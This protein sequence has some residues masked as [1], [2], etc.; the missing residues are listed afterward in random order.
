MR[1]HESSTGSSARTLK[2]LATALLSAVMLVSAVSPVGARPHQPA[3]DRQDSWVGTWA[4]ASSHGDTEHDFSGRTLRMVLHTSVGGRA[5]RVRLSNAFNERAQVVDHVTVALAANP[6]ADRRKQRRGHPAA[7]VPG[8][9]REVTFNSSGRTVVPAHARVVSDPVAMAVP[10]DSDLLVSIHLAEQRGPATAHA[11]ARQ[12]SYVSGPGDHTAAESAESYTATVNSWFYVDGLDVLGRGARGAVVA[13]GD[14]ITDGYG[15]TEGAN[16][17]WPD[18]LADRLRHQPPWRRLGVLNAG[19]SG[20][21]ILLDS[22]PGY[23][24]GPNAVSR[25]GRDVLAQTGARTVVLFEGINDIQQLPH[26]DDPNRIIAGMRQIIRQ[27]HG[28]GL[29]VV[30]G[31]LTPFQGWE[32]Y[33]PELERTRQAVNEWIRAGGAFDAVVDFDAAVRDPDNPH[34]LLPAYDSGDH[35]HPNDAGYRVMAGAVDLAELVGP[36]ARSE[37]PPRGPNDEE[38]RPARP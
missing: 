19:I 20:N 23:S 34:R 31:T 22:Q 13:L 14:S 6:H 30:G 25:T 18:F 38:L 26:Q 5:A 35:L 4:S 24:F 37:F 16:H 36:G 15:S 12:T 21:R 7:A 8:S 1:V 32:S 2:L 10:A 33:T 9:V 11:L 17:R 27:A 29:R 28:A 3:R